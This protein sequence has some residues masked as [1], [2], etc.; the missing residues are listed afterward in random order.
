[1]QGTSQKQS[2]A[3]VVE[4]VSLLRE[5]ATPL[6]RYNRMARIF[7]ECNMDY[8]MCAVNQSAT[9]F[10]QWHKALC[11]IQPFSARHHRYLTAQPQ[12]DVAKSC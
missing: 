5:E 12:M 9:I 2:I 10:H 4:T 1:M 3:D 7:S 8:H 11:T 6:S